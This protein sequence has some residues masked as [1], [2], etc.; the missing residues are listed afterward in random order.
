MKIPLNSIKDKDNKLVVEKFN[1][2][3]FKQINIAFQSYVKDKVEEKTA[4]MEEAYA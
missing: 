4:E 2:E 1:A 3:I